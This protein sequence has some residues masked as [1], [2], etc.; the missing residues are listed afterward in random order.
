MAFACNIYISPLVSQ[1]RLAICAAEARLQNTRLAAFNR[2]AGGPGGDY[3]LRRRRLPPPS[4]PPAWACSIGA[5]APARPPFAPRSAGLPDA[6]LA[7]P[8]EG[9]GA[10]GSILGRNVNARETT[11]ARIFTSNSWNISEAR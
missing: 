11:P 8:R 1:R 6:G 7:A 3:R 5:G 2:R 10:D 9:G 4:L